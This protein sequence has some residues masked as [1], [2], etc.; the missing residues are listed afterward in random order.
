[1]KHNKKIDSSVVPVQVYNTD[2]DSILHDHVKLVN[3][4]G[5]QLPLT[6]ALL[7][8]VFLRVFEMRYSY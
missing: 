7:W 5:C 2:N 3:Q 6:L 1:M 8:W 4:T